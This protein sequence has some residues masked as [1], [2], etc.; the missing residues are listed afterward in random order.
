MKQDHL[1]VPILRTAMLIVPAGLLQAMIDIL[2]QSMRHRHPSLFRDLRRLDEAIIRIEPSDLPHQF[3][4]NYGQGPTTLTVAGL[5]SH[6]GDACVRGKLESLLSLLEGQTDSDKLFFSR[7][8]EITGDTSVIVNLRNTLDREQI[9][10]LDDIAALCGPLAVP[11]RAVA[12]F[13]GATAQRMRSRRSGSDEDA[14]ADLANARNPGQGRERPRAQ[15]QVLTARHAEFQICQA[16]VRRRAPDIPYLE[17]VCPAGT[18]ASLHAAI[19]A[20]ADTVYCG[21]RD[22]TNARNYPGLNFDLDD[23]IKGVAYAHERGRKVLVAINTFPRAGDEKPWHQ[24]ID[25]A[26]SAGAD[27]VILAD[28]GVLDYATRRHPALRRHLSVQASAANHLSIAFYR[29]HFDVKRV[30]LPR[31]LSIEEVASLVR[32]TQMETEV[33]AFGSVGPMS[34][35]RCFLSSYM[36]GLSPTSE[37]ACAPASHVTYKDNGDCMLSCLGEV[38]LNQFGKNEPAAYPTPCKGRYVTR[39][40]ASYLFEEPI[41]LNAIDILPQLKAAGVTALKIEGRQRS[42]AYVTEVVGVFR[43]AIDDLAQGAI[44]VAASDLKSVAEGGRETFGAYKKGWR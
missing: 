7:E 27:A 23:L 31:V 21:F 30:V 25:N 44:A 11:M 3:V 37:G 8:I 13:M 22:C 26:A 19:D 24:A 35:G 4:L 20:G 16:D 40:S 28:I 41:G 32:Q 18:P 29:D 42:R 6:S 5:Q 9:N 34:E 2:L 12:S 39:G 17:L 36:T 33:F 14:H 15:V 10:L 38:T 1:P 43:K